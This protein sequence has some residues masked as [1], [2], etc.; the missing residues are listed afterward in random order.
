[1]TCGPLNDAVILALVC[2]RRA[3]REHIVADFSL[4]AMRELL[5]RELRRIDQHL[6]GDSAPRDEL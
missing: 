5:L 2:L 4:G 6:S 1:M 3:A